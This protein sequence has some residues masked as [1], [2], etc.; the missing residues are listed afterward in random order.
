MTTKAR[1]MTSGVFA[2]AHSNHDFGFLEEK[3]NA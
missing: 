1:N 3:L 2:R